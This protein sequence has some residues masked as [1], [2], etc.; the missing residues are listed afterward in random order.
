MDEQTRLAT[1]VYELKEREG[2]AK[3]II[4][5]NGVALRRT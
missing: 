3:V 5:D 2:R 1:D 4:E